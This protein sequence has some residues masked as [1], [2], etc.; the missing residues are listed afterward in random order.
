MRCVVFHCFYLDS[1][2]N[3]DAVIPKIH[4]RANETEH[5]V[6]MPC[7]TRYKFPC[8]L[9]TSAIACERT[10]AR[11][12]NNASYSSKMINTK[13]IHKKKSFL[14]RWKV[15]RR[16]VAIHA[17]ML[18]FNCLAIASTTRTHQKFIIIIIRRR[19][20]IRNRPAKWVDEECA[21]VFESGGG[22][23]SQITPCG[24]RSVCA[25]DRRRRRHANES[26]F[27]TCKQQTHM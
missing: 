7:N 27:T 13:I 1:R 19:M 9:L 22:I 26:E 12:R 4:N 20:R 14:A 3:L 2:D 21:Q 11:V 6:E 18:C 25:R 15:E 23:T 5:D 8:K 16:A 10:L 17:C 24:I